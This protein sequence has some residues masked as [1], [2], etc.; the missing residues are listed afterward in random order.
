M[1]LV[2][3]QTLPWLFKFIWNVPPFQLLVLPSHQVIVRFLDLLYKFPRMPLHCCK[4]HNHSVTRLV[5]SLTHFTPCKPLHTTPSIYHIEEKISKA[6]WEEKTSWVISCS[7][8]WFFE[9]QELTFIES[10]HLM[11]TSFTTILFLWESIPMDCWR[12]FNWRSFKEL[13]ASDF[14]F[15]CYS[16]IRRQLRTCQVIH[17]QDSRGCMISEIAHLVQLPVEGFLS[18]SHSWIGW[19]CSVAQAKYF[20]NTTSIWEPPF[21]APKYMFW[22]PFKKLP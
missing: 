3:S 4:R 20:H 1:F 22:L 13:L 10:L 17:V 8:L 21:S 18:A 6:T 19:L 11:I 2:G 9:C 12:S 7:L 14:M 16:W 15:S 5:I